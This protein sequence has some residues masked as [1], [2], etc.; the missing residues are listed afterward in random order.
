MT[1]LQSRYLNERHE[2][3]SRCSFQ[4][5]HLNSKA[6][7]EL[8]AFPSVFASMTGPEKGETC[9]FFL[10]VVN[11]HYSPPCFPL[12]S[13]NLKG[14]CGLWSLCLSPPWSRSGGKRQL[15]SL[16]QDL[17]STLTNSLV[18]SRWIA[19]RTE[20][21]EKIELLFRVGAK[22]VILSKRIV[23]TVLW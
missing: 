21:L 19:T 11:T 5:L 10:T 23:L 17:G 8:A 22:D 20:D 13:S 15:P 2:G 14:A 1:F 12:N 4:H 9:A 18:C 7:R 6:G 3:C 16:E